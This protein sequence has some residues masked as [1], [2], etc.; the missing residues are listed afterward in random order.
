MLK[1]SH[2]ARDVDSPG[3][4]LILGLCREHKA[5]T[6]RK[7]RVLPAI[8]QNPPNSHPPPDVPAITLASIDIHL[9]YNYL[10][11]L[12]ERFCD[13][14]GYD[15]D[16]VM[17]LD[18]W[19]Y[20]TKTES[21]AVATL[22]V[23]AKEQGPAYL[24]HAP[25]DVD[26]SVP[27]HR[28]N[29][30]QDTTSSA[31]ILLQ[32]LDS[33]LQRLIFSARGRRAQNRTVGKNTIQNLSRLLPAVFNPGYREVSHSSLH[34][35][36][37]ATDHEQA[38]SQRAASIP[39]I[40]R[41]LT[42][43]L[44]NT[45]NPFIQDKV[46]ELQALHAK[47]SH[48]ATE[49]SPS[50]QNTSKSAVHSALWRIAQNRILRPNAIKRGTSFFA[51]NPEPEPAPTQQITNSEIQLPGFLTEEEFE[52]F[53]FLDVD[54]LDGTSHEP[55]TEFSSQPITTLGDSV[56]EFMCMDSS[57]STQIT[58]EDDLIMYESAQTTLD[59]FAFASTCDPIPFD[60]G[61]TEMLF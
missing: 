54:Q 1:D 9:E 36:G 17:N 6:G 25:N 32:L 48:Q 12:E 40:S 34:G 44:E 49:S 2:T 57:A 45:S 28:K 23:S 30:I 10:P 7:G 15:L 43:L 33:G 21:F 8:L 52:D 4:H 61:D 60:S 58:M 59:E 53:E 50:S 51:S 55:R 5:S 27:G 56:M 13:L 41:A 22:A 39:I 29:E 18:Q 35:N 3:P 31:Q 14:M 42:S 38:M 20:R 24:N 26:A 47:D 16:S 37:L 11:Q 46:Q 19:H